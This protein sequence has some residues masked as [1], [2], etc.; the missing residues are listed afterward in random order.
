MHHTSERTEDER[1]VERVREAVRTSVSAAA[2]EASVGEKPIVHTGE[3]FPI[4]ALSRV[5]IVPDPEH[6]D[7]VLVLS[8]AREVVYWKRTA[9]GENPH[10]VGVQF[11]ADGS[12]SVFFGI[13]YPP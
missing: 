4:G 8:T 5:E 12:S 9:A 2:I 3:G 11:R 6:A 1:L 7:E 10:I 13:I